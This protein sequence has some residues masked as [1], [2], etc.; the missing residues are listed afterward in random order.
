MSSEERVV[1]WAEGRKGKRR[2]AKARGGSAALV[3][4]GR[5]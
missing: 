3:V 1:E 5:P 2:M 4:T